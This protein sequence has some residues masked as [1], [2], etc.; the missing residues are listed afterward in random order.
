M[1]GSEYT[2]VARRDAEKCIDCGACADECPVD[3]FGLLPEDDDFDMC[4]ACGQCE[5]VCPVDAIVMK[6]DTPEV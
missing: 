6:G 2:Q 1:G 5:D 3:C 4:G